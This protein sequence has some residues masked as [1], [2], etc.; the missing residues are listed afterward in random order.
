MSEVPKTNGI[1]NYLLRTS[2]TVTR[3]VERDAS[4]AMADD[5]VHYEADRLVSILTTD[6]IDMVQQ[7]GGSATKVDHLGE[8]ILVEGMLFDDFKAN[9]TFEVVGED[10]AS[11][12]TLKIVEPRLA[13]AVELSQLGDDEGKKRSISNI[14]TIQS[15]FSGWTARIAT[16]GRARVGFKISKR[17][18]KEEET[19]GVA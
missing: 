9:D 15:G 17:L 16:A 7:Q 4:V 19:D 18:E 12:L 8:N 5:G 6:M 11:A 10:G 2:G 3:L 13:S 14:L 1:P